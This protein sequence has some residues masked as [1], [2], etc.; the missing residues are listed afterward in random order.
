MGIGALRDRWASRSTAGTS[1]AYAAPEQF[2]SGSRDVVGYQLGAV[3]Y[4]TSAG[5]WRDCAKSSSDAPSRPGPDRLRVGGPPP[6]AET[7]GI[8]LP[9]NPGTERS[10]AT[11]STA[12]PAAAAGDRHIPLGPL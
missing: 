9:A 4:A 11:G 7:P 8:P 6:E 5:H 10:G 1:P 2:E 12:V 3:S